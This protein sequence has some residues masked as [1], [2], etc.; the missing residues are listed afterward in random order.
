MITR[1]AS[2]KWIY[3]H[4]AGFVKTKEPFLV[5]RTPVNS[6]V[7]DHLLRS[8]SH[9]FLRWK[10][11]I[12]NQYHHSTPPFTKPLLVIRVSINAGCLHQERLFWFERWFF[13]GPPTR[14]PTLLDQPKISRAN[15]IF[16]I[17]LLSRILCSQTELADPQK[18]WAKIDSL[19]ERIGA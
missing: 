17:L 3:T 11:Q 7:S 6:S 1:I 12:G 9:T 13:V 4:V 18:G 15:F 5:L 16:T 14:M 8:P 2:W 10:L 19:L